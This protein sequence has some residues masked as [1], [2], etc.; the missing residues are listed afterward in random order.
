MPIDAARKL[1]GGALGA[2]F[3]AVRHLAWYLH[4]QAG[5]DARDDD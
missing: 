4:Y 1:L 2:V 3:S 5:G